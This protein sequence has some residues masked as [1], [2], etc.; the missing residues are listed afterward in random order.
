MSGKMAKGYLFA[1]LSAVIYGCMPLMAKYI[2]ADGVNPMTL[3]FLR[4]LLA[5]P[6]LAALTFV[7]RKTLTVPASALPNISLLAFFGCVITPILLF[8][9]YQHMASGAA[10]VFHFAYPALVV[11]G[12]FLIKKK[13]QLIRVFSV[14]LCVGGLA[15]FYDPAEPLSLTGCAYA[16]GSAVT[17]ATY[18]ILLSGYK[19]D[20]ATGLLMSFYMALA[21]AVMTFLICICTGNLALPATLTGWGLCLLF[22]TAVTTGAVVL[23]QQSAFLIGG[24]KTSILST[25]EP[26]TSIVVGVLVFHEVLT[27][28]VLIGSILVIAAS[29]LI[30]IADIK[31][32][33]RS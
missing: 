23:F 9:S 13:T 31:T 30:A 24:D 10:T 15:L 8:S 22:A 28:G 20:K 27:P 16:L 29:I 32:K 12:S 19:N 3:V 5:L 6:S 2:Y 7:T 21:S 14:I 1:I 25:L 26:I 4:N 33:K 17:F 11:L 18:V